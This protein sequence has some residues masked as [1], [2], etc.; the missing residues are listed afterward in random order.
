MLIHKSK[1]STANAI[2]EEDSLGRL[3]FIDYGK[4]TQSVVFDR[5]DNTAESLLAILKHHLT[6]QNKHKAA[7][8]VSKALE[9]LENA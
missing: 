8:Y 1:H 3:Y 9:S 6:L 5:N 7:L 2:T 4:E